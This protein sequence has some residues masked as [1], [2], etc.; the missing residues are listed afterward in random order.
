MPALA[1]TTSSPA[2]SSD[3]TSDSNAT[4]RTKRSR[5]SAEHTLNRVR[6]NQRRHRARQRD[7]VASLERK[8]AETEKLLHE[9]RQEIALLRQEAA[10]RAGYEMVDCSTTDR[11]MLPSTITTTTTNTI[12][13]MTIVAGPTSFISAPLQ[14]N[15]LAQD[16]YTDGTQ[17]LPDLSFFTDDTSSSYYLPLSTMSSSSSSGSNSIT[18]PSIITSS[19]PLPLPLPL[20]LLDT[21]T[22][23]PPPCCS[24]TPITTAS[25]TTNTGTNSTTSTPSSTTPNDPECTSCKTRPPPSPTE[26][27]TLCAQAYILIG[28]QNF[29]NLDPQSIR[30]WLV[31]GL[32]RAQRQ[33]EGCRV[34]NG[35]LLRLLDFISGV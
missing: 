24:D 3:H 8:L 16:D 32:R 19:P 13:T 34:E 7:H 2:S 18:T 14:Q 5:V 35:A 26:S 9:A 17:P 28:Q 4:P 15:P 20:P 23:G 27:T 6:E 29:R 30:L 1:P 22:N 21:P 25:S 31:Q 33:G 12:S 10:Q 11:S